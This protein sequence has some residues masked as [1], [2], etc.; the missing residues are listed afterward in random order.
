[1]TLKI[2]RKVEDILTSCV[3]ILYKIVFRGHP[4]DADSQLKIYIYSMS[5][6]GVGSWNK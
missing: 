1:M 6:L 5:I 4:N 2:L 3:G